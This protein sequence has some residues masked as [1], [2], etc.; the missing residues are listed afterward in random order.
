VQSACG[1]DNVE[2]GPDAEMVCVAKDDLRAHF[3]QFARVESL[4]AA[5]RTY[6]HVD[7]RFD[8]SV[9]RG[10][11][12]E[13]RFG[14]RVSFQQFEHPREIIRETIADELNF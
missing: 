3:E 14:M 10:Q 11:T 9:S 8:N 12:P 1:T 5:L 6:G 7:R 2:A 4:D 13:A